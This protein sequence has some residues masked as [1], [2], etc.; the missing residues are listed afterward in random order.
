MTQTTL[1]ESD[2]GKKVVDHSGNDVGVVSGVRGG[3]VYVNPDPDITDS[4][5]AKLG[6]ETID[7]DDYTLDQ[8]AIEVVDDDVVRLKR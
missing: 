2:E 3:Q 7:A 4:I 8:S 1:T 6:W 5:R